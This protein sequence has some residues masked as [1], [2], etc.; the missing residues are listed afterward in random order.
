MKQ[1]NTAV[2]LLVNG[3]IF[4]EGLDDYEQ[5]EEMIIDYIES[6]PCAG[7][8]DNDTEF[9]IMHYIQESTIHTKNQDFKIAT[10]PGALELFDESVGSGDTTYRIDDGDFEGNE[11][12]DVEE[13]Q[14]FFHGKIKDG[15][16]TL[17][18]VK[19]TIVIRIDNFEVEF[20]DA[21]QEDPEYAVELLVGES[22]EE[23]LKRS[24]G[25]QYVLA[26][27]VEKQEKATVNNE[28]TIDLEQKAMSMSNRQI[29]TE[30]AQLRQRMH[31][32]QLEQS[33]RLEQFVDKDEI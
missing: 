22:F 8:E 24:Y 25:A 28:H 16:M 11:F 30:L 12:P 6:H 2:A 32:L 7:N 31:E 33:R 20:K 4:A 3:K 5:A 17:A 14:D 18:E 27:E 13:L 1:V 19:E 9:S 10:T 21:D 29:A 23:E 26:S 15:E